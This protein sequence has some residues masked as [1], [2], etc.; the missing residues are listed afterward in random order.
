[1]TELDTITP[2]GNVTVITKGFYYKPYVQGHLKL[3][4]GVPI[5][6]YIGSL[7]PEGV[8]KSSYKVTI[9]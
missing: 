3:P 1:M 5:S 8:P 9:I 6:Q 2:G 7:G 4:Y